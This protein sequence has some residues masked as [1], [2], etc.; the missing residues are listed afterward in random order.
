MTTGIHDYFEFRQNHDR[1]AE[2]VSL[3]HERNNTGTRPERRTDRMTKAGVLLCFALLCATLTAVPAVVFGAQ[4][5]AA[6]ISGPAPETLRTASGTYGLT[7]AISGSTPETFGP[8]F[9]VD[10]GFSSHLPVLLITPAEEAAEGSSVSARLSVYDAPSGRNALHD[11]PAVSL[12]VFLTK[13]GSFEHDGPGA[14]GKAAYAVTLAPQTDGAPPAGLSLAGLPESDGWRLH[15]SVRDKGMLRNGLAYALGRV[16]FPDSTPE[17]RYCEVLVEENGRYR[18]QGIYILAESDARFFRS[19]DSDAPESA[20][21]EH[22]PK[23]ARGLPTGDDIFLARTL[24]DRGFTLL[25]PKDGGAAREFRVESEMETVDAALHSLNPG[26]FLSYSSLLDQNSLIDLYILNELLLNARAAPV[27]FRLLSEKGGKLRVLPV[28]QF[29]EALDNAAVRPGALAFEEPLPDIPAPSVLARKIPVWRQLE[30]GGDIRDLRLYP[31]YVAMDGAHFPRFDRLFMSRPFLTG[32]YARYHEL[33]RGP[34]APEKVT[35]AVDALAKTLGPAL[36]RD[37]LRWANE[38]TGADSPYA[39]A[40]Y[41]DAK[42]ETR[43]RQTVSY[44]QELTKMR[45]FLRGQDAFLVQGFAQLNRTS[46]D[47]FDESTSGNRQA[48]YALATV[49]AFLFLTHLLTRKV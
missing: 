19:L 24:Q 48:G 39:L 9:T 26:T 28:W 18:Y 7:P 12:D 35:A 27:P 44:D 20:L 15:G 32:L 14:S 29:D 25:Y 23:G 43:I 49:I 40:P 1:S 6:G 47:L 45:H 37:W 2:A 22:A 3:E 34:L 13:D 41:T 8:D 36:E 16:L 4:N 21:L 42:G 5:A 10:D 30:N 31:L 38:Y 11:A 17:T 33:R 46:A